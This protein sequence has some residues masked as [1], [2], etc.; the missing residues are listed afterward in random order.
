MYKLRDHLTISR[1]LLFLCGPYYDKT[2][3]SDRRRIL[4]EKLYEMFGKRYQPLIIDDFL[5]ADNIKDP[6]ISIQLSW[7][8]FPITHS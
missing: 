5:T 8:C 7:D 4:Q 3:K 1:P 6:S 2:A